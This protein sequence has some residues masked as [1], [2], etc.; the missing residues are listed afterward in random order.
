MNLFENLQLIKETKTFLENE[1]ENIKKFEYV[2]SFDFDIDEILYDIKDLYDG[3]DI[4][5]DISDIEY[6]NF[7]DELFDKQCMK[8]F[9]EEYNKNNSENI[10]I[11]EIDGD[12]ADIS[13]YKIYVVL[14]NELQNKEQ[15]AIE[16]VD[17]LF[18][19]NLPQ[20]KVT[21]MGHMYQPEWSYINGPIETRKEYESEE[22][23][24][25]KD[26]KNLTIK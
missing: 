6:N 24:T 20:V 21:S 10:H 23:Y 16:L 26:Y 8:E 3:E 14:E 1:Q 9:E 22:T 5:S 15:F 12:A 13:D 17:Y 7:G 19:D 2:I 25:I 11:L 18:E 4:Y